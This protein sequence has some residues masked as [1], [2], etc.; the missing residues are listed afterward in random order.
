MNTQI[1]IPLLVVVAIWIVVGLVIWIASRRFRS[2]RLKKKYGSE[3]DYTLDKLGDRRTAEAELKE[4]EKR[5]HQL[6]LHDLDDNERNRYQ[7]EWT[8]VQAEFVDDPNS[9][10]EQASRLITEV[11]IARGFPVEDFEQRTADLS[12]LYPESAPIYRRANA[13]TTKNKDGAATTEDLRQAILDYRTLFTQLLGVARNAEQK[14]QPEKQ[15][16]AA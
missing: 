7:T 5:I 9:S 10:L 11:M 16:E 15:M 13:V 3:Y 8:E 1:V 2:M 6:E 12:V 14:Q 4:R